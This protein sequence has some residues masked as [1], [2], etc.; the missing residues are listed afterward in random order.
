MSGLVEEIQRDALNP[1]VP[2]S[3]ILRK[4][5]LAA[6]KLK[7]GRVENWVEQELN[8]YTGGIV[9]DYRILVGKPQAFNPY[10]G[11]IP[12]ILATDKL[13]RQLSTVNARQSISSLEELVSRSDAG[14]VEM[15]LGPELIRTL[16]AN[17]DVEF[18][19]MSIHLSV[20]QI[21]EIIDRVRN[22]ALDWATELEKAG[23]VGEGFSFDQSEKSKAASPS[24]TYN[25]HS[26][27][28][29][30][31]VM[32]SGN[33]TGDISMMSSFDVRKVLELTSQIKTAIPA[34]R[35]AGADI[36]RL[37]NAIQNIE[38]ESKKS[39][40]ETNKLRSLLTD[41]RSALVGAAGNLTAEGALAGIKGL[42]SLL[43]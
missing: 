29:F 1:S 37:R 4:V 43:G 40:P 28:S 34:L 13:N 7:L 3:T 20:I 35:D 30:N 18:G 2:V 5:K 6:A 9:P 36:D 14:F 23:I 17:M 8:G 10:N 33:T 31:G 12:I 39:S 21:Q 19:R 32:G 26:I 11:W 24:V 15:P 27:A 25:I 42:L 22:A 38:V 16:N 41:A